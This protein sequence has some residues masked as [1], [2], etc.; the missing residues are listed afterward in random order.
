MLEDGTPAIVAQL[1]KPERRQLE[2]LLP[3][4]YEAFFELTEALAWGM[5]APFT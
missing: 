5:G 2:G 1:T 3:R 4:A